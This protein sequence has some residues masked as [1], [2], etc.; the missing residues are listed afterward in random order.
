M[1]VVVLVELLAGGSDELLLGVVECVGLLELLVG[2][3]LDGPLVGGLVDVSSRGGLV[4]SVGV[5]GFVGGICV[6]GGM[7]VPGGIGVP[8]GRTTGFAPEP[9]A[10]RIVTTGLPSGPT[11]TTAVGDVAGSGWAEP[12]TVSVP[13][14]GLPGISCGPDDEFA[15]PAFRSPPAT[16]DGDDS[17]AMPPK[18]VASTTPL[19]ASRTYPLRLV[20]DAESRGGATSAR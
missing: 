12:A 16:I 6:P 20:R 17:S 7:Y 8:G 18:A 13:G 1:L 19:T 4:G 2:E 11:V 9:G 15:L 14:T 5:I 10:G 3:L